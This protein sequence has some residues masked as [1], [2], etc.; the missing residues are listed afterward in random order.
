M[1]VDGVETYLT[2]GGMIGAVV[3]YV[4]SLYPS[5]VLL[6]GT[7]TPALQIPID[8]KVAGLSCAEVIRQML[9]LSPDA[10]CEIDHS[11]IPPTLNVWQRSS[12]TAKTIALSAQR[13]EELNLRL[14]NDLI[15][16]RV[17]IA[18]EKVEEI[19]GKSKFYNII[20]AWPLDT[21]GQEYNAVYESVNLF[22]LQEQHEYQ[23]IATEPISVP[24]L[25]TPA[26]WIN[27]GFKWL[28]AALTNPRV[29]NL[30]VVA[31][32][33]TGTQPNV[34]LSSA[35]GIKPWML[36]ETDPNPELETFRASA[37]YEVRTT[38]A[39]NTTWTQVEDRELNVKMRTTVLEGGEYTRLKSRSEGEPVPV[40]LARAIYD[41][42]VTPFYEGGLLLTDAE[43][44]GDVTLHHTINISGGTERFSAIN[45][46]VQSVSFDIETG[47][48]RVQ[49]GVPN[50]LGID[51]RMAIFRCIRTRRTYTAPDVQASGDIGGAEN[52][53]QGDQWSPVE[54]ATAADVPGGGSPAVW[55]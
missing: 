42:L 49:L 27:H 30:T 54:D 28:D 53:L 48:T 3:D 39:G 15:R 44:Q 5:P 38:V 31:E 50:E 47:Q 32:P 14:R 21:T 35:G 37:F 10:V 9:W 7:I 45:A 33:R 18:Y 43:V 19:D 25:N 34:L 16:D 55:L 51:Q 1:V 11:T 40:G 26:F 6:K 17:R 22:G 13:I 2:T 8:E 24:A 36:G 23:L 12:L 29:R 46:I 52:S 4:N 20:D 41:S